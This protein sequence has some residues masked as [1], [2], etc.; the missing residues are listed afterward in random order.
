MKSEIINSIQ[1]NMDGINIFN[2]NERVVKTVV[3]VCEISKD[4]TPEQKKEIMDTLSEVLHDLLFD[5]YEEIMR[6]K[7]VWDNYFNNLLRTIPPV[8]EIHKT[9]NNKMGK[10]VE[11][12]QY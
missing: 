3:E 11:T 8:L 9:H 2:Y 1:N 7:T 6:D 4:T 12:N 10:N 5:T